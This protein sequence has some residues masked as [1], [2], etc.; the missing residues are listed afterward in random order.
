MDF[1][2]EVETFSNINNLTVTQNKPE[3][4]GYCNFQFS[5]QNERY[6]ICIDQ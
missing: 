6:E 1:H 3:A 2:T 5:L 4:S